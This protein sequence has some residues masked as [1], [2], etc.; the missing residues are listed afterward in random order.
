MS[1]CDL[2]AELGGLLSEE[3]DL[4]LAV[5]LL[6]V[7]RPFVDVLLTILQHAIDQSGEA[8]RHGG[9]GFGSTQLGAQTSVLRAEIDLASP[10][11]RG[12]P[13][14]CGG[15]AGEH[16]ARPSRKHLFLADSRVWFEP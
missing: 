16:I 7:F 14:Q 9:D 12:P 11:G 13:P 10:E 15:C 2:Q 6:V 8:V 1:W 5:S 3:L 4:L